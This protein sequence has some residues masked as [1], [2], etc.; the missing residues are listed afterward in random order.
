[1]LID[2]DNMT[3][4]N[5]NP[6]ILLYGGPGDGAIEDPDEIPN[7]SEIFYDP[8][9]DLIIANLK[10][11]VKND[12]L[13]DHHLHHYVLHQKGTKSNNFRW[14]YLHKGIVKLPIS[15]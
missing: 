10:Q 14:I 6:M 12:L 15:L 2:I 7:K 8:V 11:Y 13:K 9:N 5:I 3:K 1:M 4:A